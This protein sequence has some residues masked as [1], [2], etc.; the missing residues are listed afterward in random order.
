[1]MDLTQFYFPHAHCVLNDG[2]LIMMDCAGNILVAISYFAIPFLLGKGTLRLWNLLCRSERELFIHASVFIA[3]CGSTHVMQVWNWW[4]TNYWLESL[5]VLAT[6]VVS[7]TFAFRL[8]R[9][10]RNRFSGN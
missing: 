2:P 3:L 4:H 9:F 5:I 8:R 10:L 6:G 1:M 7:V